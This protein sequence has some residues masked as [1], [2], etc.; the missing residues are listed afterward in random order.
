MADAGEGAP[1]TDAERALME[2]CTRGDKEAFG[3]VVKRYAGRA[4]GAAFLLLGS[5]EDALD[6]SQEAFVRAWRHIRK[7]D[8]S[9]AFY[10]WYSTI[11]RNVCVS[12][13][14]RRGRRRTTELSWDCAD[15]SSPNPVRAVEQDE[16]RVRTLQVI[17]DLPPRQRE[18][19]VLSHL[20]ELSSKPLAAT[21]GIPIG[22]VMSRLH[23]ARQ[24]L[25]RKLADDAP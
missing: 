10:P 11:L 18:I 9:R 3:R 25:R 8:I 17:L 1:G 7:F 24:A 23:N 20:Q 5:R 13:L 4:T 22:T 15:P 12:R 14:R 6:A 19:I 16:R 21:L 2:R